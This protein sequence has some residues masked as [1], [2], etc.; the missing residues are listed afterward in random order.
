[1]GP[2]S[3]TIT[4]GSFLTLVGPNGSGKTTLVRSLL[5]LQVPTSGLVLTRGVDPAA[6]PPELNSSLAYVS[7]S[8]QDVL[9]ELTV[10]EY[11]QYCRAARRRGPV[12]QE[13]MR[14]NATELAQRLELPLGR[15]ALCDLSLGT[16]RKAQIIAALMTE[17]Q[18]IV[19]DELFSGLDFLSSRALESLLAQLWQ[20]GTTVI[21]I[22]HDLEL[23]SRVSTHVA[24][25]Y[26][27]ELVFY[28]EMADLGGAGQVENTIVTS[29]E[30]F[31]G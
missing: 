2:V 20:D 4:S 25:L 29:L 7:D 8:S 24:L 21:S 10:E 1:L 23:T 27:G 16:R 22:S 18:V 19:V 31:H 30:A 5:G 6:K 3:F 13:R 12:P 26:Q 28:R 15:K 11:W 14:R 17:P 9:K